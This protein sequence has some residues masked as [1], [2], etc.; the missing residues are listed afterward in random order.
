MTMIVFAAQFTV[1]WPVS[2]WTGPLSRKSITSLTNFFC[3][4][5]GSLYNPFSICFF[6]FTSYFIQVNVPNI[7]VLVKNNV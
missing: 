6:I 7:R 1:I 3:T 4:R 2:G 5:T